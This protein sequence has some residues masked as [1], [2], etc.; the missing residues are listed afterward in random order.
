MTHE[1]SITFASYGKDFQEKIVQSLLTDRMWAEQM[2]EVINTEFFD[3]KYLRFLADRYFSYHLKYKDFPTLPLL[4]SI[5]RDD[6]K[7][8]NDTILRDQI[9]D[10]L[11]RIRHNPS[12]GDLEYVKDKAL[13]FCR[14]QAFRGALEEAVDLIQADKFDDVMDLMRNALSVGSTPSIGHDFFEDMDAR[15][16]HIARNPIPTGIPKIDEKSILGGGLGKGE[17][18]VITAPTGVG[19]SHMLVSL[20]SAAL[21]AGFNVIHYTFELTETRTGLR[22][23]SNLCDIPSNDIPGRKE[24]VIA[25]YEENKDALGRLMIKE[26]P[27]GTATVQTL[28]SHIEK[29]SLKGFIPHVLVIDYADIMRSSRQYDSMRHEL[30]KVYED[31]R[32][33]AMEKNLPVWTASQSNRDAANSDVIG[34]ESMAESYGKAQIA[35]VVL[36]ISRKAEEKATGVGR[37]FVAKNR[38]GRDGILFPIMID[39][40]KS[41]IEIVDGASEMTFGEAKNQNEGDLKKLLQQKWKQVKEIDVENTDTSNKEVNEEK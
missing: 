28:R 12:M 7:T 11:Q 1:S 40:A 17:I 21:R 26:Y 41:R 27:T 10:Y 32:N 22:Y 14:K 3:L 36:S 6:L 23:D 34:L 15:F 5:I 9:V 31:L 35:D 19:K 18:G 33:L 20:G 16:I 4:V 8:G 30:K 13:D 38:A 37:L 25:Y 2:A 24:E 29:L 39:T